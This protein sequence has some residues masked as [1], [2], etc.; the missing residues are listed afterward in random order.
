ML[1][2]DKTMLCSKTFCI[3][4]AVP[5]SRN[6]CLGKGNH[7]HHVSQPSFSPSHFRFLS[8]SRLS[9]VPSFGIHHEQSRS[10]LSLATDGT[11]AFCS[12]SPV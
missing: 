6:A 8:V 7:P 11:L 9:Q 12:P 5:S 2:Q 10:E 3:R 1:H 4:L